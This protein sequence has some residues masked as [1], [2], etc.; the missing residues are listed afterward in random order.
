MRIDGEKGVK[1]KIE[2]QFYKKPKF[3]GSPEHNKL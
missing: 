1:R 3:L 2:G